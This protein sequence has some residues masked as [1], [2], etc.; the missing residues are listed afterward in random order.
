[1][2]KKNAH[3]QSHILFFLVKVKPSSQ[4]LQTIILALQK[5]PSRAYLDTLS[6]LSRWMEEED[7][8]KFLLK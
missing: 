2:L 1:M 3:T 5:I 6:I 4:H 7:W 8:S